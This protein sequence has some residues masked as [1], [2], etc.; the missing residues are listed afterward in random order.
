MAAADEAPWEADWEDRFATL[1]WGGFPA[2]WE[3]T[4]LP[5]YK[6]WRLW[7]LVPILP[8]GVLLPREASREHLHISL[9]FDGEADVGKIRE[10][11]HGRQHTLWV[12]RCGS[13]LYIHPAD[14]MAQCP[15]IQAV[16]GAGWYKDRPLHMSM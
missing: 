13:C 5:E 9:C 8:D 12:Y 16:H 11:W 4:L 15:H 1:E 2:T 14:P 6:G 7:A 3:V 10:A